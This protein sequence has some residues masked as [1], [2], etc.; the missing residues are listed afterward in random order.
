MRTMLLETREGDP[1]NKVAKDLPDCV[2]YSNVLWKVEL[3]SGGI[4]YLA[5]DISKQ[6]VEGTSWLL[7]AY[8]KMQEEKNDLKME[9]LSKKQN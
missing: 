8:G 7:T 9:L 6:N 1:C 2:L 4:R 3:V 5:E